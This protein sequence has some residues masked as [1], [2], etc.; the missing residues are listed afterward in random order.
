[1]DHIDK[2]IVAAT[3]AA[4]CLGLYLHSKSGKNIQVEPTK[5]VDKVVALIGDIGGTNVRL[6]IKRLDLKN[7]T[8]EVV[9][10]FECFKS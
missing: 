5:S 9:K 7:N 1:M 6:M 2:R 8:S 3:C 10:D 4:V